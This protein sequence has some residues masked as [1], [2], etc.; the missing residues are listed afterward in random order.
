[1]ASPF[2][3]RGLIAHSSAT[4]NCAWELKSAAKR[5]A[6]G[7]VRSPVE[8]QRTADETIVAKVEPQQAI[9]G[10]GNADTPAMRDFAGRAVV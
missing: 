9:G 7:P 5:R 10:A 1:M 2:A 8:R 3:G 6:V 4:D